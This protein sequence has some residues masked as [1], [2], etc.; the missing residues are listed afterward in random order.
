MEP[1]RIS[2]EET[3]HLIKSLLS[4]RFSN[5]VF[6]VEMTD[7]R[8]G[9]PVLRGDDA[10]VQLDPSVSGSTHPRMATSRYAPSTHPISRCT[11]TSSYPKR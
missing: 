11:P 3:A 7:N 1:L 10:A 4:E 2:A 5:A 6:S 9:G 8:D